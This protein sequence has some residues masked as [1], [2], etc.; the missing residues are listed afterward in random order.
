[1]GLPSRFA[2]WCDA[3]TERIIRVAFGAVTVISAFIF[4]KLFSPMPRTFIKSST[5]LKPPFFCRYSRIRSAV[6]FPIPGSVS[7]W[8]TVAVFKLIGAPLEAEEVTQN[9]FFPVPQITLVHSP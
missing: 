7:S 3:L 5:F 1:M 6:D 9:V 4:R 8:A 2:D